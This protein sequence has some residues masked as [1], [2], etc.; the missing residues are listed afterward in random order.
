[1]DLS[2]II[3][4]NCNGF[5]SHL[6]EIKLLISTIN[7]YILCL[8]E[9]HFP[10]L[11]IPKLK[12]FNIYFKIFSATQR[13]CGGVALLINKNVYSEEI[14]INSNFQITAASIY[15]PFKISIGM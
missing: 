8:Q 11:Y 4:W 1:M 6:E 9:T 2:S 7:P 3:Q 10:E 5:Y 12:N 13:A 14:I 15:F